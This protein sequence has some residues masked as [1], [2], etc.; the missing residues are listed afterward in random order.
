MDIPPLAC[1]YRIDDDDDVGCV[2]IWAD[3]NKKKGRRNFT[4]YSVAVNFSS[5]RHT[6]KKT[7]RNFPTFF[8]LLLLVVVCSLDH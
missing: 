7:V 2:K 1:I 3:E 5:F 8:L 6:Q 4:L